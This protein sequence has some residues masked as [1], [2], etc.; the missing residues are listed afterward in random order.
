HDVRE[1]V[2]ATAYHLDVF[3]KAILAATG[4]SS[5]LLSY[6]SEGKPQLRRRDPS[7]PLVMMSEQ[8]TK[9]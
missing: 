3:R 8:V 7:A 9:H 1:F 5:Y 6:S 4:E 2:S